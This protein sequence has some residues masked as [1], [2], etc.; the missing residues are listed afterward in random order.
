MDC[1]CRKVETCFGKCSLVSTYSEVGYRENEHCTAVYLT[2][3]TIIYPTYSTT[4][5]H[6]G[7]T[8]MVELTSSYVVPS[9]RNSCK[10]YKSNLVETI[11]LI[12]PALA[13]NSTCWKS[14]ILDMNLFASLL[15][16]LMGRM[17]SKSW[18]NT[19]I[20]VSFGFLISSTKTMYQM[21][22]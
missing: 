7:P 8:E 1:K 14:S 5:H 15:N 10:S 16:L 2:Y 6:L 12:R 18:R 9:Q 19:S 22:N 4:I 17:E 20:V 13:Q 21:I 11:K 3:S